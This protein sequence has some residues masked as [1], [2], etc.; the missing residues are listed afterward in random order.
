MANDFPLYQEADYQS[1]RCRECLHLIPTP[2]HCL[3]NTGEATCRTSDYLTMSSSRF[4]YA[5]TAAAQ[6][7]VA[8]P[9]P[10]HFIASPQPFQ[11]DA[12]MTA[13]VHSSQSAPVQEYRVLWT[14]QK[15]QKLKRW[16]DGT[17]FHK[18]FDHGLRELIFA[19]GFLRLHTF[20]NRMLLYDDGRSLV[21]S[22]CA[23]FSA[24]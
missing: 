17:R 22:S 23:L 10:N 1:I 20:N 6:V 14:A 21:V 8:S 13:L 19:L 18:A 12:K 4:L 24:V 16:H 7:A 3:H 11:H 2:A 9:R 5:K 15:K